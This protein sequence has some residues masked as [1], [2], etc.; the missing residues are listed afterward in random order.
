MQ[1]A[2]DQDQLSFWKVLV[3]SQAAALSYAQQQ[4]AKYLEG[5][6]G[7]T[8]SKGSTLRPGEMVLAIQRGDRR[9]SKLSPTLRGPYVVVERTGTNRYSAKHMFTNAMIDVH[10]DH[11]QPFIG[12]IADAEKAAKLD[13]LSGEYEVEL[14]V[15]H[16]FVK[17]RQT[18]NTIRFRVR[19]L[20]WGPEHDSWL[21]YQDI[22]E[23]KA[24]DDYLLNHPQLYGI[25]PIDESAV[26]PLKE[27]GVVGNPTNVD[28]NNSTNAEQQAPNREWR[29]PIGNG[30][31]LR[32]RRSPNGNGHRLWQLN[33]EPNWELM[34]SHQ[35][36]SFHI[37]S[38]GT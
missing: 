16:K 36:W 27:G 26:G 13:A 15:E 4:Q 32:S 2:V 30:H 17:K 28:S 14:I 31:R 10:L 35:L 25:V 19:W 33:M 22:A 7:S 37:G 6:L 9:P 1:P 34:K 24:L 38:E 8:T 23:L 5:Y 21:P 29:N 12:T 18:L 20:G 3:E 11:L